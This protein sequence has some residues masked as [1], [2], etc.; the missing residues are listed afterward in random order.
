MTK[1][2][3]GIQGPMQSKDLVQDQPTKTRG[4]KESKDAPKRNNDQVQTDTIPKV[5]GPMR[6]KDAHT[7]TKANETVETLKQ[8]VSKGSTSVRANRNTQ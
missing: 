7:R 1:L 5:Q 4:P 6:A 3:K 2:V 8:W